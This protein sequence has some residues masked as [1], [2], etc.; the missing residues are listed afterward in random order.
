MFGQPPGYGLQPAFGGYTPLP[1]A[2]RRGLRL[3]LIIVFAVVGLAGVSA[4]GLPL[5]QE[6]TRPPTKAELAAASKA[7]I[8]Q[9][10]RELPAG[11]IFPATVTY[12]SYFP[13]Y[14]SSESKISAKARLIGIAPTTTCAAAATARGAAVLR[15][16]HCQTMLR[17]TYADSSGALL[18][19]VGVAVMRGDPDASHAESDLSGFLHGVHPA[20]FGG[21]VASQFTD[22]GV[23]YAHEIS[24]G[25]YTVIDVTGYAD[26]RHGDISVFG[27]ANPLYFGD[28]VAS[29]VLNTL[30]RKIPPCT[31]ADVRC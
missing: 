2:P 4:G 26:G 13:D 31:A 25:P 3:A 21:T 15:K 1:P 19:T 27:A 28:D 22:S 10:W 29:E 24:G 23:L 11:K 18:A 30:T 5:F 7:E 6:L 14:P 12:T 17:A 8:A 20:S 16:D 9:R